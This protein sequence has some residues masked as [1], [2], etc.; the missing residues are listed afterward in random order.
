MIESLKR[1]T[2]KEID[3]LKQYNMIDNL[4]TE[5]KTISKPRYLF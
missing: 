2:E 3:I 4:T 5:V 1:M